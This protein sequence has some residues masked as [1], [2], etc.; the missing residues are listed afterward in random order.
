MP[1]AVDLGALRD[2]LA[3]RKVSAS[4]RGTA[5]RLSP[6]VYNDEADIAALLA[7]LREAL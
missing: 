2:A 7:V 4:L 6:N 3:R 1:P 5:L